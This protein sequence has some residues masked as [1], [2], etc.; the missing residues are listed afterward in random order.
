MHFFQLRDEK[1]NE[2]LKNAYTAKLPMEIFL[3]KE[4]RERKKKEQDRS[5]RCKDLQ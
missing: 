4:E 1:K 3:E 5:R 2:E